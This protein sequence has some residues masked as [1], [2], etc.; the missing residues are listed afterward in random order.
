ME[1]QVDLKSGDPTSYDPFVL[2]NGMK[3]WPDEPRWEKLALTPEQRPMDLESFYTSWRGARYE[4]RRGEH[5]DVVVLALPIGVLPHHCARIIEQQSSWR[6]MIGAVRAVETQSIRLWFLPDLA[7]LGWK[8]EPPIVSGYAKPFSTWED[9]SHL[10]TREAWPPGKAP[11]ALASVFGALPAPWPPPGPDDAGYPERQHALVRANA[12]RWLDANAGTLW[13]GAASAT[14]P[15]A[16]DFD[17]LV[18]LFNRAGEARLEFQSFRA[19]SG[20]IEAYTMATSK[21]LQYR[22]RTDESGYE[23]LYLA[24]DWVR[25]GVGI[26]SVEGAVVSGLQASRAISGYPT[27]IPNEEREL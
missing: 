2:V 17:E 5:F 12:R 9:D 14:Q 13:P 7:G 1:R 6:D 3:A 4:L 8:Y 25:N 15:Q 16:L 21:A 27:K 10:S 18:D 23:N 19:N 11:A 24:G 22:L 20:P 26:G